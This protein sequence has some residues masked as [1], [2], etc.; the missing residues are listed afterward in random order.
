MQGCLREAAWALR[1]CLYG[2]DL[3]AGDARQRHQRACFEFAQSFAHAP[4]QL[5][6]ANQAA[7]YNILQGLMPPKS[8]YWKNNPHA[9]DIDLQIESDFIGMICPGMPNVS[10]VYADR[11]GHIMNYGDGWYGGVFMGALYTFAYVNDDIPTI[12]AEALKAIP[13]RERLPQMHR[14]RSEILENVSRQL[15]A[16]LLEVV[17]RHGAEVGCPDGIS[18]GFDIDAKIT[19]F[20][21]HRT[22]LRRR[23]FRQDDGDVTRCGQDSTVSRYGCRHSW[24]DPR[25]QRHPRHW[26]RGIERCET[27]RSR[28]R[29]SL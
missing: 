15:E 1:R 20:L 22:A 14:R 7:R 12:V 21:C 2:L 23:R 18:G 8:G 4:Y 27:W 5:W 16:V 10:P 26:R 6:H 9:D 29:I 17:S 11:I 3:P 25:L 19:Y 13:G 28:T 24:R